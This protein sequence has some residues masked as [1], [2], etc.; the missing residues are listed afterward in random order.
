MT[1]VDI[2]TERLLSDRIAH[3][4][5]GDLILGEERTGPPIWS[6]RSQARLSGCLAPIDG[7]MN[8]V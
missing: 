4:R 5:P 7:A 1:V 6:V 8:F 3:L 2:E